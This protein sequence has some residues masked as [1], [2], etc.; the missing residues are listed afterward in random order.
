MS[1]SM[2]EQMNIYLSKNGEKYNLKT[3]EYSKWMINTMVETGGSIRDFFEDKEIPITRFLDE[4]LPLSDYKLRRTG[5]ERIT[6]EDF[7]EIINFLSIEHDVNTLIEDEHIDY[8]IMDDNKE[9]IYIPDQFAV[10]FFK[11]YYQVE[12]EPYVPFDYNIFY[13]EKK[14]N[15][16]L[17]NLDNICWN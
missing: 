5:S 9:E 2:I 15:S 3:L 16:E 11:E 12:L 6:V 13:E 14:D 17:T 7:E 4:L 8:Y 1:L 10:D